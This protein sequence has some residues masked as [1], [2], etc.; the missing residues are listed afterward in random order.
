MSEIRITSRAILWTAV[1]GWGGQLAG[2]IVFTLLAW[3][4][5]PEE[6]GLVALALVFIAFTQMFVDQGLSLAIIQHPKITQKH[7]STAF[8]TN[9]TSGFLLTLFAYLSAGVA[10][11][12]FKQPE[13]ESIVRWLSPVLLLNSLVSVQA[14]LFKKNLNF[15]PIAISSIASATIGGVVG[16]LLAYHKFGVWSLIAQQLVQSMLQIV[17]LWK[18]SSWRPNIYWNLCQFKEL[19]SYS[20]NVIGINVFEFFSRYSDNLLIGYYLGPTALGYYSLAYRLF[21]TLV[22]L[23]SGLANQVAFS[24]FSSFQNDIPRV[25]T[26]FYSSIQM[27][28]F[29]SFPLFMGA[30]VIAPD[31]FPIVFGEKWQQSTLVFQILMIVAVIESVL[32]FNGSVMMALG[33]P[34]WRLKLNILNALVNVVGF[35]VSVRWGIE[36]VALAYVLRTYFLCPIALYC[37]KLLI[38]ISFVSYIK[39]LALQLLCAFGVVLLAILNKVVFGNALSDVIFLMA[40]VFLCVCLYLILS[41][42]YMRSHLNMLWTSVVALSNR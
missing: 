2:L 28:A 42:L 9:C 39:K 35:Y 29:I 1:Q 18:Q 8:W 40:S 16:V 3:Y 4:L 32:Y 22:K 33:K 12:A 41:Y 26:A 27:M 5:T 24:S 10:A 15:K 38:D 19:F 7:L 23:I 34:S 11:D 14:A 20:V 25:R 36:Y 30:C 21:R 13:L 17:F 37:V 31:L 6:F